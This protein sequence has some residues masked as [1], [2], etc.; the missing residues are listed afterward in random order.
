MY[1]YAVQTF[2]VRPSTVLPPFSRAGVTAQRD[3]NNERKKKKIARGAINEVDE[4]EL[5]TTTTTTTTTTTARQLQQDNN[6]RAKDNYLI[7]CVSNSTVST[8]RKLYSTLLSNYQRHTSLV[9]ERSHHSPSHLHRHVVVF[10][11]PTSY[12]RS[13]VL[14]T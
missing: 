1:T 6:R 9:K 4:D 13:V 14:V 5:A 12:Q 2:Q 8:L 10:V 7:I 11:F 3:N